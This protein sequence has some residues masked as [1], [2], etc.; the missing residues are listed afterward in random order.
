VKGG[1]TRHV[2][3]T[4]RLRDVLRAHFARCRFAA[5]DGVRPEYVFHHER[6]RR[7]HRAGQRVKSFRG[8]IGRAVARVEVPAGWVLHD[9]RHRRVTTWLAEG[10]SP[11]LVK[12]ALGHADLKT[13]MAYTHLAKEHLRALVEPAATTEAVGR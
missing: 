2:P 13:T 4:A 5:Y 9:L 7:R 12:E 11:V 1:R 8:A 6:T 10:K 3:M